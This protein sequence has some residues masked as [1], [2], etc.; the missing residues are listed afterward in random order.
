MGGRQLSNLQPPV[1]VPMGGFGLGGMGAGRG[2]M[3]RM[4]T[5]RY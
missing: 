4:T 3:Y 1:P 2:G 5:N